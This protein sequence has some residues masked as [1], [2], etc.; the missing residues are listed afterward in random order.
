MQELD[1]R[2][3]RVGQH[4]LV[5]AA[6]ER[7]GER[8]VRADALAGGKD[9]MMEGLCQKRRRGRAGGARQRPVERV[10]DAV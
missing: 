3:G 6:G 7:D 10:F 2:R 8:Q 4:R 1:G 5:V 9:R